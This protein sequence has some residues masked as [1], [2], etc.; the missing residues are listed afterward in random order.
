V[1]GQIADELERLGYLSRKP[2]LSDRRAKRLLLTRKGERLAA[3]AEATSARIEQELSQLIGAAALADFKS[4]CTQ[5]FNA[6]V[7]PRADAA[8]RHNPAAALPLC[9][10][11]LATFCERTLMD[12]DKAS[13]YRGLKMSFA[14]VLTYSSPHGTLIN[15][16]ARI[17]NVS[18]QAISQVVKQVEQ[19]GYVQRRQ[20]PGDRRS[21]MIFLTDSGLRLIRDSLDNL[22]RIEADLNRVLGSSGA[23]RFA[24][25]A[26]QL[27]TCLDA[28]VPRINGEHA[29]LS[30]EAILHRA[31]ERLYVD[32][33]EALRARLF[34]RAGRK[35]KLSSA[36]LKTLRSLEIRIPD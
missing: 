3:C 33:G 31:M 11:G 2:D 30:T 8:P 1:A 35:A 21:T 26:E 36:V 4:S 23:K 25:T 34:N 9:L 6:L 7:A 5:L 15:D 19:F 12:L 13:G 22:G 16:L 29:E 28:G 32:S 14:Q 27:F 20:H 10:A 17:N 24:T 18:K